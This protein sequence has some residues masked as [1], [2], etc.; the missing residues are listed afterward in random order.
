MMKYMLM[1]TQCSCC[2]L[3]GLSKSAAPELTDILITSNVKIINKDHVCVCVCVPD[4]GIVQIFPLQAHK[5][6]PC[7]MWSDQHPHTAAFVQLEGEV[8]VVY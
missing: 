5:C 2:Q 4:S 8:I 3:R 6:Q 1:T 7:Q